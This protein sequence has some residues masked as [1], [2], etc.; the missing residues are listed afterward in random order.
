MLII[1]PVFITEIVNSIRVRHFLSSSS[2]GIVFHNGGEIAS[3][4]WRSADTE[5]DVEDVVVLV[6]G[7]PSSV[8]PCAIDREKRARPS[9]ISFPRRMVD[10]RVRPSVAFAQASHTGGIRGRIWA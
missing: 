8:M 5:Q 10:H 4:R 9:P 6:D 7:S 2:V 1:G 3:R